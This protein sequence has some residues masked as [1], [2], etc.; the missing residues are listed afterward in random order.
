MKKKR[1]IALIIA[2]ILILTNASCSKK[3]ET[4]SEVTEA[5]EKTSV[6]DESQSVAA[7]E[8]D[9]PV[10]AET[11]T[12]VTTSAVT[13][14]STAVKSTVAKSTA[15]KT[16]IRDTIEWKWNQNGA[17]DLSYIKLD[18]SLEGERA[19]LSGDDQKTYDEWLEKA[20][21][22]E[23][24]YLHPSSQKELDHIYKIKDAMF[25]DYPELRLYVSTDEADENGFRFD[26]SYNWINCEE[27]SA[28]FIVKYIGRIENVCQSILGKMKKRVPAAEKYEFILG[29]LCRRTTY[30]DKTDEELQ[31]EGINFDYAYCYL[32]GPLLDGEGLCQAYAYAY[33]LLCQ[34]EGLWCVCDSG[35]VHCWN[36]VMLDNGLTYGVD[37]TWCDADYSDKGYDT[38]SFLLTQKELEDTHDTKGT[39]WVATGTPL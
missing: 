29:E 24:F 12:A 28:D 1:I 30:L 11:T 10:D 21:R 2:G 31:E 14:K 6:T 33:Q 7:G 34:R 25:G 8:S 17:K 13:E 20:L 26:Y 9:K 3:A 23:V 5:L 15:P 36:Q 32:N 35:G 4:T 39:H 19:R 38:D 37:P 18:R 16:V 22:F 27:F